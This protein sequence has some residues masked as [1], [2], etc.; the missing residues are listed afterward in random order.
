VVVE[1]ED[2]VLV[3][4]LVLLPE[5]ITQ[6]QLAVVVLEVLLE[7]IGVLMDQTQY[8]ALLLVQAVVVDQQVETQIKPV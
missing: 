1:L 7:V 6:L 2:F 4:D 5:L 8:L 3:Q